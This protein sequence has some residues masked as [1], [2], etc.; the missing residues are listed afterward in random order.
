MKVEILSKIEDF[1]TTNGDMALIFISNLKK[2]Y[3]ILWCLSIGTCYDKMLILSQED[4]GKICILSK[5]LFGKALIYLINLFIQVFDYNKT[6]SN[7]TSE[8]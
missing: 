4:V 3:M 1:K 8:S 2:D 6:A 7:E 5:T